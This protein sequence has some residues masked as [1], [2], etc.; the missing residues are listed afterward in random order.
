MIPKIIH[1]CW[2]SDD[3]Y[4][5]SI[6]KCID[7]WHKCLPD[8]EIWK[9]D[10][11]RF[12]RGKSEWV[13]QAFDNHKYAF[14]ADYIRLYALHHYGGIY[15]DSD[16]EVI[17]PFDD[18]LSLP[19][20]IG[21]ENTPLG[22][23]AATLGCE[24]GWQ[25]IADLYHR[26]KALQFV[27]SDGTMNMEPMPAI[28]RKCI[29]S[30][31]QLKFIEQKSDFI[32]DRDIVNVFPVDFFSPKTWYT[33]K[34]QLTE[35]TYSI[36]HFAASWVKKA[37]NVKAVNIGNRVRGRIGRILKKLYY[38]IRPISIISNI[39]QFTESYYKYCQILPCS[40]FVEGC[41]SIEDIITL[42]RSINR[43]EDLTLSFIKQD[44]SKYPSTDYF[45]VARI[46]NTSCEIRYVDDLDPVRQIILDHWNKRMERFFLKNLFVVLVV[47][48]EQNA[49][50]VSKI[51]I[52]YPLL[53]LTNKD[54]GF[55]NQ[56]IVSDLNS[57]DASKITWCSHPQMKTIV[58]QIYRL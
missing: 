13:D 11:N 26:Y 1:F 47:V 24:K 51:D 15:L 8:Y 32:Y 20:F 6:Q 14:A 58:N 10:F 40:P 12:P 49:E 9:W 46:G 43:K 53:F 54:Y 36:H 19:Y 38:S 23:E 28:F 16:V 52:P 45:P 3:P 34:V 56:I 18:L 30:K 39:R 29:E 57:Y 31:Y 27:N 25:L 41:M 37:D 4:P 22:I 17:K 42:L 2:L 33:Q 48:D 5:E 7:S 50:K 21:Q 55:K 35:R 44:D